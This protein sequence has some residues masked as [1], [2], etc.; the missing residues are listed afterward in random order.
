LR[1][2]HKKKSFP[3]QRN[4]QSSIRK[5]VPSMIFSSWLGTYADLILVEKQMYSFPIRPFP[6]IFSINIAFTLFL[7]PI[8]TAFFLYY[9][10]KLN[11]TQRVIV[12]LLLGFFMPLIEQLSE[13]AGWFHHSSEW[14]HLYSFFGYT[15]FMWFVYKFHSLYSF[16]NRIKK[17]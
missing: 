1:L 15:F 16:N 13:K 11:T 10:E 8:A 17:Y 7:L 4:G 2:W 5:Y 14:R 6:D 12:V 3:P 9:V